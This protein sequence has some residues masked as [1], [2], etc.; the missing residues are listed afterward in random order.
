MKTLLLGGVALA[1]LPVTAQA[2]TLETGQ[3]RLEL[4]GQAPPACVL[5]APTSSSGANATFS[6]TGA[7]TGEIRISELV[8]PQTAQPR[9]ASINL[10]LPVICNSAHRLT[11][12]SGN[13]GMLRDGGN[14][15]NRQ[16]SGGF[17]DFL[18]YQLSTAWAGRTVTTLTTTAPGLAL[19]IPDGGAGDMSVTIAIP[20][21][22]GA[23]VA[24]RYA[25]SVIINFQ[26]AS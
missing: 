9:A 12:T 24:G 23:L 1:L 6:A 3:G 18:G 5:R 26:A 20:A 25:D 4:A 2:Q 14:A 13:G 11:I 22:G 21:G 16:Q 10:V 8:D 19:D 17:G 7:A 15:R